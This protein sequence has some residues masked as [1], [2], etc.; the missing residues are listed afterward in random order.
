MLFYSKIPLLGINPRDQLLM[1]H[2]AYT[3][4][5]YYR[6]PRLAKD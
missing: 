6:I 3:Q 5:F 4:N 2:M 1:F